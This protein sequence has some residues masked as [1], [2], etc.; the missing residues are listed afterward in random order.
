M[1]LVL[2]LLSSGNAR[3]A[4]APP[5]C[6]GPLQLHV[7][8]GDP[9]VA[10]GS[11]FD[12]EGDN[13]TI[14]ITQQAQKGTAEVVGQGTKFA[15]VRYSASS[16][17]ADSFKFKANDGSSDSNEAT[18]TTVNVDTTPPQTTIHTGPAGLTGDATPT[19]EF[20][21]SESGSSF[22]CR[23]DEGSWESCSS[24][25]TLAA[26]SDGPHKFEVR[27]TDQ[28]GNPD[29]SP[30][31]RSFTVDTTSATPAPPPAPPPP[32]PPPPPPPADTRAPALQL[33]GAT[34]QKVLRQRGVLMMVACPA[35]AC[36]ATAKGRVSVRGSATVFKLTRVTKQFSKGGK[37]TLKLKL[38]R[39]AL[40]AIGR[41]LKA[42]KR[43]SAKVTVTAK[44][45]AGNV[46][47]KRR[48]IRLKR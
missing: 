2:L 37:A 36:T 4:G 23:V 11:C 13:L 48:T 16:V 42:S 45:A 26:L 3:A 21:A 27:A 10:A 28:A 15:S 31:S 14:T 32:A 38:K 39:S 40:T 6:G 25:V 35:E 22:E 41:A 1:A 19:F 12:D 7:E 18:T 46:T 43:L 24:P 8:V 17:G 44:D 34:A 9:P 47:T 33:S 30:D 29:Q 5:Q 20:S